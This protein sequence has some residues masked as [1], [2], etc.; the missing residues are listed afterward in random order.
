VKSQLKC[1]GVFALWS[2]DPADADITTHLREVFGFA[3]AHEIEFPN[4][5]TKSVSVNAVYVAQT[6]V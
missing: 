2:N 4:P 5:Y 3:A 6:A 1:G